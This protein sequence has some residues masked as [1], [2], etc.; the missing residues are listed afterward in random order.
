MNLTDGV[1]DREETWV[2]A[3]AQMEL[4]Y[5]VG[6]GKDLEF[7]VSALAAGGTSGAGSEPCDSAAGSGQGLS[8]GFDSSVGTGGNC[9]GSGFDGRGG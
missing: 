1:V 3:A 2:I 8:G 5:S 6:P 9:R 7:L 4:D